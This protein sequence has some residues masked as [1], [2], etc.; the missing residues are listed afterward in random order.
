M[1][2][3]RNGRPIPERGKGAVVTPDNKIMLKDGTIMSNS[4]YK[5]QFGKYGMRPGLVKI[6]SLVSAPKPRVSAAEAAKQAARAKADIKK[7]N[8]TDPFSKTDKMKKSATTPAKTTARMAAAERAKAIPASER[9]PAQTRAI[10]SASRVK[11]ESEFRKMAVDA[12]RSAKAIR[13]AAKGPRAGS[14]GMRGGLGGGL[15]GTKNR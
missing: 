11:S 7:G 12:K 10:K 1:A 9:T 14:G 15:F 4:A 6:T 13:D 2:M 5:N 3:S 8:K